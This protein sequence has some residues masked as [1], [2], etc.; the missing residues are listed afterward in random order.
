MHGQ[1]RKRALSTQQRQVFCTVSLSEPILRK[2]GPAGGLNGVVNM[3]QARSS[4]HHAFP[5]APSGARRCHRNANTDTPSTKARR[6][7]PIAAPA[8]RE[9]LAPEC[10]IRRAATTGRRRGNCAAKPAFGFDTRLKQ[11][12]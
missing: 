1:V 3:M 9:H 7:T 2:G 5:S 8:G 10:T 11:A 12:T 6:N 4:E